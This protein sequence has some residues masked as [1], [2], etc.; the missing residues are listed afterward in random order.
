MVE[1]PSLNSLITDIELNSPL[2]AAVA[3]L[4]SSN[5]HYLAP[6]HW[7]RLRS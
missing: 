7:R 6:V 3:H 1:V 4:V 5:H 2:Y